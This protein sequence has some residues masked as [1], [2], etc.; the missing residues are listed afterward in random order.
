MTVD[1][2]ETAPRRSKVMLDSPSLVL[3]LYRT[4]HI[5]TTHR[6][7]E[8]CNDAYPAL[9]WA[10][11]ALLGSGVLA[12]AAALGGL[13]QAETRRAG[14]SGHCRPAPAGGGGQTGA[15]YRRRA[16]ATRARWASAS[17][18]DQTPPGRR[19]RGRAGR[20]VDRRA[21]IRPTSACRRP[22]P[23]PRWRRPRPTWP[24]AA[25]ERSRYQSLRD[26]HF[27]SAT[28]IRRRGQQVQGST[29]ARRRSARPCPW[30]RTRAAYT[31]L[32]ADHAGV[33]TAISRRSRPGRGTRQTIAILARD[34]EREVEI[35][36][37]RAA[38]SATANGQ[39]A[40]V[41]LWAAADQRHTGGTLREIAPEADAITRTY[42]V[43]RDPGRLRGQAKLGQTAR[44]YFAGDEAAS[45]TVPLAAL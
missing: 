42:R 15:L 7:Q 5:H 37:A 36:R 20:P 22:A 39:A 6:A 17:G 27:V 10:A 26:R 29:G 3:I 43:R 1:M 40:V 2:A 30:R 24:L 34:G 44:V 31:G 28:G 12:T 16:R 11:R 8:D 21:L 33:I 35:Q 14:A 41:E 18:Q 38:S 25:A 19:G 23:A 32:R 13:R 9:K 45:T 4:V